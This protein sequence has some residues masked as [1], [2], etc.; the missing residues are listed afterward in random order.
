MF[1]VSKLVSQGGGVPTS[2]LST[3]FHCCRCPKDG[4]WQSTVDD[5]QL[6][7]PEARMARTPSFRGGKSHFL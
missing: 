3:Q 4:T 2:T 1:A 5:Q 6:G 7:L